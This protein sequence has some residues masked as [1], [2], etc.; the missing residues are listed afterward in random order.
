M[1]L[2]MEELGRHRLSMTM[3]LEWQQ[4]NVSNQAAPF[5]SSVQAD[6]TW[7][8]RREHPTAVTLLRLLNRC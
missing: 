3:T 4:R 5:E 1:L 6:L 8:G 7:D 2:L